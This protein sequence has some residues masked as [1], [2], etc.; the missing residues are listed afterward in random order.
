MS[1]LAYF[2]DNGGQIVC[3]DHAGAYLRSELERRPKARR[4]STPLGVWE[5]LDSLEVAMFM[6]E[7]GYC[8]ETCGRDKSSNS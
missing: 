6:A 1:A 7:F 3:A 5:R 4:I 2:G 8:C